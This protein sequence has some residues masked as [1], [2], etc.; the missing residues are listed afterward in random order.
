[1]SLACKGCSV[2][3]LRCTDDK[4]CKR[5]IDRDIECIW[6][7]PLNADLAFTPPTT[8]CEETQAEASLPTVAPAYEPQTVLAEEEIEVDMADEATSQ[9][10]R[11]SSGM[12]GDGIVVDPAMIA[13]PFPFLDGTHGSS[14]LNFLTAHWPVFEDDLV[15]DAGLPGD[16]EDV[17]YSYLNS[18][19]GFPFGTGRGGGHGQDGGQEDAAA[20][21]ATVL[22]AAYDEPPS[23]GSS[24]SDQPAAMCTES[25]RNSHWHFRPGTK[26]FAGA[27]QHHLSL[28]QDS[29]F[30]SPESRIPVPVSP[31]DSILHINSM[32]VLTRDRILTMV[33]KNANPSH[34]PEAGFNFPSTQLLDTLVRLYLHSTISRAASFI[35]IP[36]F[37]T[38]DQRPELLA[39]MVACGAV[40]TANTALTKLG[41]AIA[42]IARMAIARLVLHSPDVNPMES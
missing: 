17:Q 20:A 35:H 34:V 30:D 10:F 42:E 14:S 23:R 9:D 27:E 8:D 6:D 3:H 37:V 12:Q 36:T 32:S 21:E 22:G 24:D 33:V 38:N 15:L 28:P 25:L 29:D 2:N 7:A 5:C 19:D 4:P 13:A 41:F 16:L 39:A 1:M 31:G 40:L 26:D 11:E 18:H